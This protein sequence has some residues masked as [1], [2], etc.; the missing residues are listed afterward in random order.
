M[1]NINK[2]ADG[3]MDLEQDEVKALCD[4]LERRKAEK[5]KKDWEDLSGKNLSDSCEM[6]V[7]FKRIGEGQSAA[8]VEM[9]GVKCKEDV[10]ILGV[11]AMSAIVENVQGG[12]NK[13]KVLAAISAMVMSGDKAGIYKC[14]K[15]FFKRVEEE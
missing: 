2:I 6:K 9:S 3:I 1:E 5:D 13:I 15:D 8:S 11:T 14:P 7:S 4:E 10:L 12:E